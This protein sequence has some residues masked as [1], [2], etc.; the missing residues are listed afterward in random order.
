MKRSVAVTSLAAA[1]VLSSGLGMALR[2]ADDQGDEPSPPAPVPPA[3]PPEPV[4]IT[5][6]QRRAAERAARKRNRGAAP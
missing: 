6:Q 4:T 2:R 1:V 5:R 3:A